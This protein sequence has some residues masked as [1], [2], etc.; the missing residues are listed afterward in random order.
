MSTLF[1]VSRSGR[2]DMTKLTIVK[3]ST[4]ELNTVADPK[5]VTALS[6]IET[7]ANGEV[8]TNNITAKS[9]TEAMLETALA[10]KI[11]AKLSGYTYKGTNVS[12]EAAAGE[13]VVGG[14]TG[15]TITLPA[16]TASRAISVG[17]SGGA[18][19]IKVTASSGKIYGLFV[20]GETTVTLATYQSITVEAD[21]ANW[22]IIGGEPQREQVYS[23][24]LVIKTIKAGEEAILGSVTAIRPVFLTGYIDCKE[25]STEVNVTVGGVLATKAESGASAGKI[26]VP[27]GLL[28]FPGQFVKAKCESGKASVAAA[29]TSLPL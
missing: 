24:P 12:V 14:T 16:P 11:G 4:G 23:S 21:G 13:L 5:V 22:L 28:A 10:E 8:G 25:S 15:I 19:S 20:G 2:L 17:C 26:I 18:T 1:S 9:I 27:L 7:W 6:V 3:P 29:A